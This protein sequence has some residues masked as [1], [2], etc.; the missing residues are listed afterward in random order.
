MN[1]RT[2]IV[3]LSISFALSWSIIGFAVFFPEL[4]EST[5][6]KVSIR[7]P[8]FYLAVWT[9]AIAAFIVVLGTAGWSG[10]KRYLSRLL[11]WRVHWGWYAFLLT[12]I[13]VLFYL[14]ALTKGLSGSDLFPVVSVSEYVPALIMMLILGP[15]EEFGWRGVALPLMQRSL[16]PIWAGLLLGVI[17][18]I[19]HFPA[20]LLSGT[21]QAAWSFMPFLAGS[22]SISV[23]VTALFNASRGSILLP[24]LLHWQLNNP[25]WPDAQPYDHI[26]WVSAGI[27]VVL[28]FRKSMFDKS[29]GVTEV[30][31]EADHPS[32]SSPTDAPALGK[33]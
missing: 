2:L 18:G 12:G 26:F 16:A 28:V 19:W 21:P 13:P 31:P 33:R 20:F 25:A 9:P 4:M 5:F 30:I 6:G 32:S 3:F 22:V 7:N 15:M 11:L 8:L 1:L 27:V 10:F 17:W 29:A 14:G 24:L 23:V